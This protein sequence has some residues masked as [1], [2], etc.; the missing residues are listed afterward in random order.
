[1]GLFGDIV[2]VPQFGSTIPRINILRKTFVKTYGCGRFLNSVPEF[3]MEK[4][5]AAIGDN[6]RCVQFG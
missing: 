1:M 5:F 2:E 3:E 6:A 4:V